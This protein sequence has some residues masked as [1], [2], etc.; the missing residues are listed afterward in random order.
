[1]AGTAPDPGD[2]VPAVVRVADCRNR[3]GLIRGG[4]GGKERNGKELAG[5]HCDSSQLRHSGTAKT[6][7][8]LARMPTRKTAE[9]KIEKRDREGT[10]SNADCRV[11]ACRIMLSVPV[12]S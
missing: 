4:A 2:Q 11:P 3:A 6:E 12:Y 7:K 8:L 9:L 10:A 1:V 5:R